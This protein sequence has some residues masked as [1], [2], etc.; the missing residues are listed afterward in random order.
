MEIDQ[1]Q[2]LQ[3]SISELS[4][5]M[6]N[7]AVFAEHPQTLESQTVRLAKDRLLHTQGQLAAALASLRKFDKDLAVYVETM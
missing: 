6:G 7:P 5:V 3:K 2:E 1:I 4:R